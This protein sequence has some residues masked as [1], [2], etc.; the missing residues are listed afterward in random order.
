MSTTDAPAREKAFYDAF[1]NKLL[2][3]YVH[4]NRRIE[5]AIGFVLE[6]LPS[7]AERILDVGCGIGWSSREVARTL[8]AARVVGCDLSV[9]MIEVARKLHGGDRIT[10]VVHDLVR[11]QADDGLGN[12]F[13]A[14]VL[15]DVY[16]HV[17]KELRPAAHAALDRHLA[18]DARL[19]LTV[20]SP[21]HQRYLREHRPEGLQPVDEDV[22]EDDARTLAE[23][24]GG[25][26]VTY[27]PVT[28]WRP[29]DY[30][31]VVVERG[32]PA[33]PREKSGRSLTD[34]SSRERQVRDRLGVRVTR[35]GLLLADRGETRV[36]VAAQAKP[37]YSE[38]FIASHL[39]GLTARVSLVYGHPHPLHAEDGRAVFSLPVRAASRLIARGVKRPLGR[40]YQLLARAMPSGFRT[41]ALRRHLRRRDID[42][43]LAEYGPTAVA[44]LDACREEGIPLVSHFHG[45]DIY[46]RRVLDEHGER[47]P[48]LFR[49]S[50]AIVGVSR[51]M[52]ERLVEMGA[53]EERV[54]WIPCGV[55]CERL[56]PGDPEDVPPHFAAVGR[57]V[58]KK[59]PYLTVLA[60]AEV[61]AD[62]KEAR[63]TMLGDGPELETC[64]RLAAALGISGRVR[65]PGAVEHEEV[66]ALLRSVRAFVQHSV[67]AHSGDSEGTPVAVT[68]AGAAALPVVATRHAG[69]KDLVVDGETG[70]L[71]EEGDVREMARAMSRLARDASL[72]RR[73]GAAN[74]QRICREFSMARTISKLDGLVREAARP[75]DATPSEV[76]G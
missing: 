72:A 76:S 2:V 32:S 64:R 30:V 14:A 74:R 55:D 61:A 67:R 9:R 1:S 8:M 42:V 36:C 11:S 34:R 46:D 22:T 56:Q 68:E 59:A 53:P 73:M 66:V 4:G 18:A 43:V 15:I 23:A 69:I 27:R 28:V 63:L 49:S 39:E 75:G 70:F 13:E 65:F 17:S 7:G 37:R 10:F 54:H 50:A 20:P 12:D 31:H 38:T 52:V 44:V 51:D 41:R 45:F 6:N 62:V 58:H 29:S 35:G 47:Y 21:A 71:V 3:D 5:R 60:F 48:E 26:L 40:I 19:I 24:L 33:P 57:F 16:E 25:R